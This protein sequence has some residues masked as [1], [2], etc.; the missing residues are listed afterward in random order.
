[1][2]RLAF[3]K[4]YCD[5]NAIIHAVENFSHAAR[6]LLRSAKR[7]DVVLMTS[8]LTLHEVLIGPL[9][10]GNQDL[11]KR[12][13][14]AVLDE[15]VFT[16][17]EVDEATLIAA[18]HLRAIHKRLDVADALHIASAT[19]AD[20]AFL[21]SDDAGMDQFLPDDIER[22]TLADLEEEMAA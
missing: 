17:V 15:D 11:A 14:E 12:Y 22:V 10:N 4:I 18:A 13:Q 16:L 20:C 9:G 5:T 3:E 19:L 2:E 8:H 21:L 6:E 7:G 1:M